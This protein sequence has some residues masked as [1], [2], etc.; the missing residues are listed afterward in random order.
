MIKNFH[1]KYYPKKYIL[2]DSPFSLSSY[3][4]FEIK[5]RNNIVANIIIIQK[6]YYTKKIYISLVSYSLFKKFN[7]S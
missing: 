4:L 2:K 6:T 5:V 3:G 7:I 1:T